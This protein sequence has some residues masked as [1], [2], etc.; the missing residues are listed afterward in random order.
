MAGVKR[1]HQGREKPEAKL[2]G[3]DKPRNAYTS[4]FESF[5]D[6]LEESQARRMKIGTVSRD[7]TALSKKI[8]RNLGKPIPERIQAEVD[9][10]LREIAKLLA[11]IEPDLSGMN[12]YRYPP[13]CLEELVEALSFAHYLRHQALITPAQAQEAM[14]VAGIPLTAADYVFGVFDLTGEMM[15]FATAVTALAGAVPTGEGSQGGAAGDGDDRTIVN[16]MQE[17]SSMFQICPPVGGKPA[18]YGKKMDVMIEQVLKVERLGYGVTVRGTERP[19]GWMPDLK[20]P[21]RDGDVE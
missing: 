17:V 20:E 15:R 7:V 9:Q 4:M 21:Q 3:Q 18:N 12:R 16:D 2:A 6:E 10:R 8:V 1:D 19:K 14:P 5:R 11:T 13:M